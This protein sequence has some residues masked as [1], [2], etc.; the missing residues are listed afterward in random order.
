M[1]TPY[2]TDDRGPTS[3]S[4]TSTAVS[5]T[6]TSS[7]KRGDLPPKLRR[8]GMAGTVPSE[9]LQG[10]AIDS[11][12]FYIFHLPKTDSSSRSSEAERAQTSETSA[13]SSKKSGGGSK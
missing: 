9:R 12:C 10:P 7:P 2:H 8:T 4:P 6:N 11:R 1:T 3:T 13:A 5:A